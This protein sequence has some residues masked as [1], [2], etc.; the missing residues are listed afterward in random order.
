MLA[1]LGIRSLAPAMIR[2]VFG[3]G[4]TSAEEWPRMPHFGPRPMLHCPMRVLLSSEKEAPFPRILR[5]RARSP[6]HTA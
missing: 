6:K 1:C 4:W 2:T 3:I 5:V